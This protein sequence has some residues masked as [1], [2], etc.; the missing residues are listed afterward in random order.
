MWRLWRAGL[1]RV[2]FWLA[3]LL[4]VATWGL[5]ALPLANCRT[6]AEKPATAVPGGLGREEVFDATG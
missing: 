1:G 3:W 6:D 5:V 4:D 2:G